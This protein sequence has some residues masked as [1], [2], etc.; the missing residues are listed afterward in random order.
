M[1]NI[2]SYN[3]IMAFHPGYYVAEI[4]ECPQKGKGFAVTGLV[5]G[6]CTL[7]YTVVVVIIV[8][9]LLGALETL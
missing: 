2:I 6:I 9:M 3:E 7:I 8:G 4:V 1:N 5:V